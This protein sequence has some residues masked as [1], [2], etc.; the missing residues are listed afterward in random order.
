MKFELTDLL[1]IAKR[2]NNTLRPYLFVNPLQG[3]HIPADPIVSLQ[4]FRLLAQKVEQRYQG[5]R[6]LAIG[7]AE[8]AT[9]IGAAVA[10]YAE[11]VAYYMT[12]TREDIA[13][14]EYLHFTES[15]SHATDQRL[16]ANGLEDCLETIDRIVF[17]EDEVT[18]GST[19]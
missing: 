3:K 19:I 18:T 1:T 5:E 12:T 16:I 10:W 6:L 11:N 7:F 17:A 9:A 15:H 14:A 4:L 13:G 2:D 8:T